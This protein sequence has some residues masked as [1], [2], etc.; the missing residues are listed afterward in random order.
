MIVLFLVTRNVKQ[1]CASERMDS[2]PM[3]WLS[4]K[5]VDDTETIFSH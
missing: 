5:E 4:K 2:R 3:L 1:S